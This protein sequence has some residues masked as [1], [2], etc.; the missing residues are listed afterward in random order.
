M[1]KVLILMRHGKAQQPQYDI[2]DFDRHLTEA[3]KRALA[4][5]LPVRA[6]TVSAIN[7]KGEAEPVQTDLFG[8]CVRREKRRA[9]EDTVDILR[10]R[11]GERA[12]VAA[13]LLGNLPLAA[14]RCETVP[15]PPPM[16]R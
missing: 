16:Y 3:G 5:T 4:A 15:M 1:A 2:D 6:L 13:S 10:G 14:D 12:V 7:L 9:L 8:D 11:F